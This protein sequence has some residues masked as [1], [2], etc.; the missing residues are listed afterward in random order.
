MKAFLCAFALVVAASV[1]G[2]AADPLTQQQVI[3]L[4]QLKT[5][6]AEVIENINAGGTKFTLGAED[7]ARLRRAGA[8]PAILAAMQGRGAGGADV[9]TSEV[10]DLCLVVDYSGSMNGKTPDGVTKM[11]AAKQAVVKLIDALPADLNVAVV[12]Y[13]TNKERGCEDIDLIHPLGKLDKETVKKRLLALPNTGFTPIASSLNIAGLALKKAT[14]GRAIILVTDGVESCKGEP[15]AVAAKLAAEF[16]VKFGLHLVGFDIKPE[17][18]A[19]LAAIARS[20]HGQYF[21]AKSAVEFA[22]A[23]QKVTEVVAEA[24]PPVVEPAPGPG[25]AAPMMVFVSR[26]FS[27]WENP[28]HSEFS[29]NGKTVDIFTSDTRKDI[30]KHLKD[31]WN[32]LSITTRPQEPANKGNDL[33]FRIGPVHKDTKS[34]QLVMDPVLWEFRNGTD[35]KLEN[36]RHSHPLGPGTKEVTLTF[37]V[38]YAGLD[39]E[40]QEIKAGDYVLSGKPDFNSWNSPVNAMVSVNGTPLNSFMLEARQIVVTS[41]LKE[42]RNEVKIVSSRVKNEF[43]N[44]DI[45]VSLGGPAEYIAAKKQWEVKP[46][47]EFTAMQGWDKDQRSGQLINTANPEADTI[48]RVVPFFLDEAPMAGKGGPPKA[49]SSADAAAPSAQ[50][51]PSEPGAEEGDAAPVTS[52]ISVLV[53]R[54]FSS[55]ENPLHS[56]F[57]VNGRTIDIFSS[58]T[59]K[60]IR[61]HLKQ[62]WNDIS[63][64]TRPQEP[65]NQGNDLIFRIG[66][67]TKDAQSAEPVMAPV[68]WMF[69]N[70]SDWE[71]D[72]GRYSHPLGPGT[73]EVTLSIPVF[74]AGMEH[75]TAAVKAGDY[76]LVGKPGFSSWDSPVVA[77]VYVNG[78][79]LN[80]FTLEERQV[81][82]TPL[83]KPGANEI[84]LVSKR[85]KNVF[86]S[87]DIEF[88]VGGPAEWVPANSKFE[89]KEIV[90][91]KAMQGWEQDKKTGQLVNQANPESD[92]IERVIP[93]VLEK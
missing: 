47:V 53:K 9:T 75:E 58:D 50:A 18:R 73:K 90:Q 19:S 29:I 44:N 80:S 63:I 52:P 30:S 84:K 64:T 16:G 35:W 40:K 71:L 54:N 77:M 11:T 33:I 1:Q 10:S 2:F 60:D 56:E 7:I 51:A 72:K 88:T 61:K 48:E 15:A 13:G 82:I 78:T 66:P 43:R 85:V 3:Q 49:A 26:N 23:M 4:L 92:T 41:L 74:F 89:M 28:L 86:K 37:P 79:P 38:F 45:Q 81:V 69:R 57:S 20:G 83:L 36:G 93:F 39:M 67:M 62:G 21:N 22:S 65:A 70:G 6:E 32:T 27:S 42:G 87:N 68:L 24:A 34:N 59:Q 8:T 12:V 17:E 31:G 91:F 14:A 76:V 55:W 46:I 25:A 5:P